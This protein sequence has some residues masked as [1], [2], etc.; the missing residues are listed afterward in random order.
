MLL[1]VVHVGAVAAAVVGLGGSAAL[2]LRSGAVR[3]HR[4]GA[5]AV[6]AMTVGLAGLLATV[7][8]SRQDDVQAAEEYARHFRWSCE[9]VLSTNR[10]ADISIVEFVLDDLHRRAPTDADER[11]ALVLLDRHLARVE[12][13]RRP[14]SR[15]RW[16]LR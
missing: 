7:W 2:L 3:A 16:R 6:I 11:A 13:A 15:R 4:R 5:L 12:A 10:P 8:S 14:G 9:L 1:T